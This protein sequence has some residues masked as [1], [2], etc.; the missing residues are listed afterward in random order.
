MF[1]FSARREAGPLNRGE[2]LI[3][4][5]VGA[6]LLGV[7]VL[8][9]VAPPHRQVAL[10]AC[11]DAAAGC[12]VTVDSDLTTF[13]GVLAAAGAL[14]VLLAILGVRFNQLK[15]AGTEFGYQKETAG[16]AQ[17]GPAEG[18]V[19]ATVP[20]TI[21]QSPKNVPVK[22]EVAEGRGKTLGEV[23]VA[24]VR[25]V[26]PISDVDPAFLSDYQSARRESQNSY[27]LTHIL[28]PAT[29]LGQ[30]YSVAIRVTAHEQPSHQVK[31]AWFFLGRS[32]G[33][34]AIEGRRGPDGRFGI[35]TEAYGPFLA[36]CE[37]EF[38]DGSRILLDHYCDFDMGGLLSSL[39]GEA[40]LDRL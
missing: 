17:A 8:I 31:S 34:K 32:W 12:I 4:F 22:V 29:R 39:A 37:I 30:K 18:E 11:R 20:V 21:D 36:L 40:R 6:G 13:A 1:G 35:A 2:R 15:V 5:I 9:V 24:V 3:A 16:L 10:S 7:A 14:A 38:D 19:N 23:P 28:G 27:F 26:R 33:N 25:L